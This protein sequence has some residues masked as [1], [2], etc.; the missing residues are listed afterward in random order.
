MRP[1]QARPESVRFQFHRLKAALSLQRRQLQDFCRA[2]PV[3]HRHAQFVL[4]GERTGSAALLDAIRRELGE[5]VWRFVIGEENTLTEE[6]DRH[7]A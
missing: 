3:S 7:A 4:S 2:L 6:G 5:Q 1:K